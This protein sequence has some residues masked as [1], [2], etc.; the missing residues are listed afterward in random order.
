M[1]LVKVLSVVAVMAVLSTHADGFEINPNHDPELIKRSL[2]T[3][4][5][6][7]L[8]RLSLPTHEELTELS[9]RCAEGKLDKAWCNLPAADMSGAVRYPEAFVVQGVRWNDDPNNFFNVDQD[10]TWLFWLKAAAYT[11]NID[12]TYPL[13]YR[14][15]YGDLQFL[16]GMSHHGDRLPEVTHQRIVHWAHFAYDVATRRI[17]PD[18]PL[19]TLVKDYPFVKALTG[20]SKRKWTVRKLFT[21]VNDVLWPKFDDVPANDEQLAALALGALLH[22]VQDSFS[23]SH[24]ERSPVNADGNWPVLAWLDY[25]QQNPHCHGGA[26]KMI[27]WITD[28]AS[29]KPAIEWGSRIVQQAMLGARWHGEVEEMFRSKV[30]KLDSHAKSGYAG[31]Y[32]KCSGV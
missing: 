11:P 27:D 3:E 1:K 10:V 22:T 20:T 2:K 31:G 12:Q 6:R 13:E 7:F 17:S 19:H 18:A 26:D 4:Y 8:S 5:R 15:H 30:F 28:E 21:N 9:I 23:P 25:K 32:D 16:H 29:P 14:S 24:V